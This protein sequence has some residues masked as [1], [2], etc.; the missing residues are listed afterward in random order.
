MIPHRF[1]IGRARYIATGRA[2]LLL[3]ELADY[4]IGHSTVKVHASITTRS[5][6]SLS[7]ANLQAVIERACISSFRS[8]TGKVQLKL[9][10]H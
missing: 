4:N 10:K 5:S 8:G 2:R 6:R 3:G 1:C 9:A 7:F